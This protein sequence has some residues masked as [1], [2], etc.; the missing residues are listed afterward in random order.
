M[1]EEN[2]VVLD[3]FIGSGTVAEVCVVMNRNYIGFELNENNELENASLTLKGREEEKIE[4]VTHQ[5]RRTSETID[6]GSCVQ[7]D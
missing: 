4:L 1:T 5:D 2:D 3:P 7:P 6:N